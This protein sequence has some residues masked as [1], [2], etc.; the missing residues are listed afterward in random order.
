MHSV[1]W[2]EIL[3]IENTENLYPMHYRPNPSENYSIFLISDESQYEDILHNTSN[4]DYEGTA[5]ANWIN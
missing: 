3:T 4:I 5:K 2:N 1:S